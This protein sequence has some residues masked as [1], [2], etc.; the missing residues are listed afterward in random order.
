MKL[1]SLLLCAGVVLANAAPAGAQQTAAGAT[2]T[3][4]PPSKQ[5]PG[6]NA[7]IAQQG[8]DVVITIRALQDQTT[9]AIL[10]GKCTDSGKPDVSGPAQALKPLVNGS[11]QTVVPNTTV[12]QLTSTPHVIVVQGGPTPTLCGDVSVV[13]SQAPPQR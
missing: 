7:Q 9:A 8:S 3:L 6:G 11:S 4:L 2:V 12:A 1:L 13:T 10:S 5:G